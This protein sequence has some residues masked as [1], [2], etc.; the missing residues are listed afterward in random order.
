MQQDKSFAVLCGWVDDGKNIIMDI[1]DLGLSGQLRMEER[2]AFVKMLRRIAEGTVK[3]VI[4][5]QVDRLFR[6]RWGAEYSKFMEICFTYGVKVV[7]PNPY[8]TGIEFVYDFSIGWHVDK[9]RRKCEEAWSYMENHIYGRMLPAQE[10]LGTSGFWCGGNLPLGYIVDRREKVDG[11]ENPLY[12]KFIVY[13]PHAEVIRWLFERFRSTGGQLVV[14]LKE[15]ARRQFLFPAFDDSIDK[16]IMNKFTQCTKAFNEQGEII[17]Y[18]I[19]TEGGLRSMLSNATYA[20]YWV[21][22]GAVV[23][24]D[25]HE[26]IVDYGLFMYAFSR[27]SPTNLDGTPNV[28]L[29][30]KRQQ[31][32]KK[33]FAE[34]PAFLKNHLVSADPQYTI[35]TSSYPLLVKGTKGKEKRVETFYGF[36]VQRTAWARFHAKYMI[37]TRD[38]DSIFIAR[39][40]QRLQSAKGYEGFLAH[41]QQELYEQQQLQQ[42]IERDIK[43]VKS[44]MVKLKHRLTLLIDAE[45]DETGEKPD[46]EEKP[47]DDAEAELVREIKRAYGQHKGELAR[48]EARQKEVST[49]FT[50]A[51]TRRTYKQLMQDAGEKWEEIVPP[52]EIP[53]MIDTFVKKVVLEPL[54]PHFYKMVIHWYDPEW[55]IDE[56]VCYR[57]GNASIRWTEEEDE[58]LRKYYPAASRE[59]LL[60]LLPMRNTL[61]QILMVTIHLTAATALRSQLAVTRM[62]S[63]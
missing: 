59:E 8:R 62:Y 16:E 7:T 38:V 28:A 14:L 6:D 13:E 29:L 58:I 4:A 2:P 5:A 49:S 10:Q 11:E 39:F 48:L 61:Y 45:E 50:Q 24:S 32:V 63:D 22:R 36:Y 52:E 18:T 25:N 57:D 46:G 51:E 1:D 23:R 17:G 37:T 26:T 19:K 54:T 47:E 43:T 30:E 55:G 21:Y 33:H 27:L 34:R 41:E 9:F 35:Y 15:I 42:D 60:R 40:I 44:L 56:G 20:G 3:T 31:Y 12:L 53:L